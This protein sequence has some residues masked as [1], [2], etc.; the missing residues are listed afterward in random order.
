MESVAALAGQL[1]V[2][3][4]AALVLAQAVRLFR[5]SPWRLLPAVATAAL[6]V[7]DGAGF[8]AW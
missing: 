2:Q 7:R 3:L 1:A 6:F 4:V 5:Q 8:L